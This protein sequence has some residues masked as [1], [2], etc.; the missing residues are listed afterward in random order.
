MKQSRQSRFVLKQ[1]QK[2]GSLNTVDFAML[3]TLRRKT[4]LTRF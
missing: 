3:T 4:S 2:N 1:A